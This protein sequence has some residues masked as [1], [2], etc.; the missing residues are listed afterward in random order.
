MCLQVTD[1]AALP[2]IVGAVGTKAHLVSALA[3]DA[4]FL[5]GAAGFVAIAL[6]AGKAGCHTVDSTR[7][8]AQAKV[9]KVRGPGGETEE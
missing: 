5:A 6:G 2:A 7:G 1:F 9:T 4:V 3:E 8:G